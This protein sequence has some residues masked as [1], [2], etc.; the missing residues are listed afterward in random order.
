[1]ADTT[2]ERQRHVCRNDIPLTTVRTGRV[3]ARACKIWFVRR[4]MI[5]LCI[6][7]FF[8]SRICSTKKAIAFWLCV[9]GDD[10]DSMSMYYV[11]DPVLFKLLF[12]RKLVSFLYF[13]NWIVTKLSFYFSCYP[14][15]RQKPFHWKE[16]QS[17]LIS[18]SEI[19]IEKWPSKG[20]C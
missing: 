12:D 17:D 3:A 8:V 5:Q 19:P 2:V 10:F 11:K 13:Q 4:N 15:S 16:L 9:K 14:Q 7:F 1:M 18:T 6:R 20:R